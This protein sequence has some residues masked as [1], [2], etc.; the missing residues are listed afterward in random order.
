MHSR[1]RCPERSEP[2]DNAGSKEKA[3]SSSGLSRSITTNC[4]SSCALHRGR[5]RCIG[6]DILAWTTE[7][8]EMAKTADFVWMDGRVV[9]WEDAKVHVSAETVIRGG[10]V[11]ESM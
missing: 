1:H 8:S 5:F 7:G 2:V 6:I 4:R 3:I 9:A 11:F 10:N